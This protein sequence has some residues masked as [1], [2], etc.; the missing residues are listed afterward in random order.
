MCLLCNN[1][2]YTE[3]ELNKWLQESSY[4]DKMPKNII[5]KDIINNYMYSKVDDHNYN[6][7]TRTLINYCPVCGKELL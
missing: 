7:N 1:K 2:I 4:D 3:T 5:F 6:E